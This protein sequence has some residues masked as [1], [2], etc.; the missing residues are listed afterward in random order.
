MIDRITNRACL[1]VCPSVSSRTDAY[2]T[3]TKNVKNAKLV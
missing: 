3:T 2:S 1:A